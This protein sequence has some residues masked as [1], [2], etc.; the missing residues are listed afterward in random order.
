[1][2]PL[3]LYYRI[4]C[5]QPENRVLLDRLFDVVE[6]DDP[7]SD[8]DELLER[9]E[10]LFAPLGFMV[11]EAR[12]ARCPRLRAIVSNTTGIPHIDAA[13]AQ[14]RSIAVCA[15][16]DDQAFLETITPTAEHTIG[17]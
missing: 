12:I 13:A 10:V 16:H 7:R 6:C 3:A 5:Y 11:D 14:R 17:L 9:V 8:T 1:M 15:L 2:R 4:L